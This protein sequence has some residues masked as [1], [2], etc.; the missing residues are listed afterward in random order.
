[1]ARETESVHQFEHDPQF[2]LSKEMTVIRCDDG[3]V[4]EFEKPK[5][6]PDG[7]APTLARAH[8]PDGSITHTGSRA[9]LP[10]AVEETVETLLGGWSK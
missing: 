4:Y 8:Q 7:I 10:D 2:R 3:T 6:E 9:V 1:M 5:D